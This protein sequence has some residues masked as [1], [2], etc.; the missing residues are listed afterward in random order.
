MGKG[1]RRTIG[2]WRCWRSVFSDTIKCIGWSRNSFCYLWSWSYHCIFR[3]TTS[4]IQLGMV[5]I[6]MASIQLGMVNII[7]FILKL[8]FCSKIT[9][10]YASSREI[11][12][13]FS[14]TFSSVFLQVS[15]LQFQPQVATPVQS[16]RQF[17]HGLIYASP[18]CFYVYLLAFDSFS[19]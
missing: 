2:P 13:L 8:Y 9:S 10:V 17:V 14:S 4:S 18:L 3:I 11:L 19:F 1:W 6:C 12:V 16:S 7:L 15:M 5:S